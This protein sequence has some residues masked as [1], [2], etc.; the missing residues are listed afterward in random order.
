MVLDLPHADYE[1]ALFIKN[2]RLN[3]IHRL[4]RIS[5]SL[6]LVRTFPKSRWVVVGVGIFFVVAYLG[7]VLAM[8]FGCS[9]PVFIPGGPKIPPMCLHPTGVS[10]EVALL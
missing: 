6:S 8:A 1:I 10:G 3:F 7:S 2:L 5:L 4:A 9:R